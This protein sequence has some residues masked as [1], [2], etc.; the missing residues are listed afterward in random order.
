MTKL[1][2]SYA[3]FAFS[4]VIFSVFMFLEYVLNRYL[5]AFIRKAKQISPHGLWT[6]RPDTHNWVS[7]S[8]FVLYLSVTLSW[9]ALA[10]FKNFY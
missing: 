1:I 7:W 10:V 3:V 4:V 2:L 9:L 6:A 5:E 8:I